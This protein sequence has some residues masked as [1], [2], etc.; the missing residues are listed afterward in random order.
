MHFRFPR[1]MH[2]YS[3]LLTPYSL[4][5]PL[6]QP[7]SQIYSRNLK[8]PY[9]SLMSAL[10]WWLIP[11]L[12]TAGALFYVWRVG[13]SKR[14]TNIEKSI[15]EYERFRSAFDSQHRSEEL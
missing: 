8:K 5:H 15:A 12:G 14:E 6:L 1:L 3:L 11:L 10:I 9:R 4:P 2:S 7:R 13:R